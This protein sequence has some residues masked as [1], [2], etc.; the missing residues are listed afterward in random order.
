MRTNILFWVMATGIGFPT[1]LYAQD[2]GM[3]RSHNSTEAVSMVLAHQ[4]ELQL[5]AAQ[6][7][8]LKGIQSTFDREQT[9]LTRVGWRGA[10]GKSATPRYETV[11]VA[12]RPDR[13]TETRTNFRIRSFDRV[14]GKMVPR[15]SR[16]QEISLVERPCPFT[17]LAGAQMDQVHLLLTRM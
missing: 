5:S 2:K 12:A 14:P 16:E 15:F 9:R 3:M 1:G 6:L 7:E 8:Q 11:R 13:Y 4:D 17:F 10:P